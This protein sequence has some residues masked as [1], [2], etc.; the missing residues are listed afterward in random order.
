[1]AVI[2]AEGGGRPRAERGLRVRDKSQAQA[3]A[4]GQDR[5]R[6]RKKLSDIQGH[7]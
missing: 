1:L 7:P 3:A 4:I 6:W 2:K 5:A